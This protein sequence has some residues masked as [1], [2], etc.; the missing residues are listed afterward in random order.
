MLIMSPNH[1]DYFFHRS[2]TYPLIL[3]LLH[4]K[5]R[6]DMWGYLIVSLKAYWWVTDPEWTPRASDN[7][8]DLRC[9]ILSI[10]RNTGTQR[11]RN[12]KIYWKF[13]A[14]VRT[15]IAGFRRNSNR[16][17]LQ[18]LNQA[19]GSLSTAQSTGNESRWQSTRH[20]Q[21]LS[22]EKQRKTTK[23]ATRRMEMHE[24]HSNSWLVPLILSLLRA[25][26]AG[27]HS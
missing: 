7:S 3:F 16:Q 1:T 13:R 26:L 23:L 22:W 27:S 17:C 5:G 9:T 10:L 21:T 8:D 18:S 6:F 20:I 25:C 11:H 24:L 2:S 4:D 19:S 14:A 15:H 12:H